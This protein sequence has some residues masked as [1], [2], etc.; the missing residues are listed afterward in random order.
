M[1]EATTE[2]YRKTAIAPA[3]VLEGGQAG[4]YMGEA[5]SKPAPLDVPGSIRP[6]QKVAKP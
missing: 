1:R 5:V 2:T 6:F 4:L 3:P